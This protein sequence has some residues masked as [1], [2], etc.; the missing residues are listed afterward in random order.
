[1]SGVDPAI[2]LAFVAGG[3]AALIGVGLSLILPPL[4]RR[5][6]F[7]VERQLR[8]PFPWLL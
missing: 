3:L 5:T 6:G 1:M 4:P 2:V 7:V 8:K